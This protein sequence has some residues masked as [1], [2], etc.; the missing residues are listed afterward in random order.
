MDAIEQNYFLIQWSPFDVRNFFGVVMLLC[1]HQY[2]VNIKK[3][4]IIFAKLCIPN[5]NNNNNNNN[6]NTTTTTTNKIHNNKNVK[7]N[8]FCDDLDIVSVL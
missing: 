3:Y 6:I 7:R 4:I 2:T 8:L 5:N 1:L